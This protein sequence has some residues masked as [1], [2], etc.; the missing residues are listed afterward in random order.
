M[1]FIRKLLTLLTYAPE[2]CLLGRTLVEL[3]MFS[4]QS[5]LLYMMFLQLVL[6][7][8]SKKI[9]SGSLSDFLPQLGTSKPKAKTSL[10]CKPFTSYS[11]KPFSSNGCAC[12]FSYF[13]RVWL[14]YPVECSL[15]GCS[16]HGILQAEILEWVQQIVPTQ[17]SNPHLLGF[18]HC[19][20]ILYH[21]ATGEARSG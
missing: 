21:W 12:V 2:I 11:Q 15:P 14:C 3:S 10:S 6:R 16:I 8:P 7:R 17:G 9:I 13:S 5:D 20:Q 19:R 18:L 4:W 1:I